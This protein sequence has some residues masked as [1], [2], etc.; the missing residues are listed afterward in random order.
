MKRI[1]TSFCTTL[2]M[3]IGFEANAGSVVFVHVDGAGISHWQIGRA[4]WVGP[5]GDLHWDKLENVAVYR[6]LMSDSLTASSNGGATAHAYGRR[7]HYMAFGGDTEGKRALNAQGER[8]S[9]T[10]EAIKAGL[11]T[12]LVNSGSIIEPGTSAFVATVASRAEDSAEV[13]LQVV[14]SGVDVILSG[15]EEWLLPEGETGRYGKGARKDGRNLIEE[16]RRRGYRVVFTREELAAVPA[17]TQKLLGVFCAEDTFNDMGE[18]QMLAAGLAPYKPEAPTLAEMTAKALEILGHGGKQFFLAVEEEGTD[19]FGNFT[20]AAGVIEAV[21]RADDALGVALKF[22][23]E[24]DDTLLITTADSEAG[25]MEMLGYPALEKFLLLARQGRDPTGAEWDRNVMGGPP[26]T[27]K[28]DRRLEEAEPFKAKADAAGV[29][30]PFVVTWA[31]TYDVS[32]GILVRA[33]GKNSGRV[34]GSMLNTDVYRIM[35]ETL[36]DLPD[37]RGATEK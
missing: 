11:R 5:D 14:E 19:N 7:P 37:A 18:P 32:G 23:K 26:F 29:E 12:G 24:R 25:G 1:L 27:D 13:A 9:L 33:A 15:G 36:F 28:P 4:I 16:A 2:A 8:E 10:H 17:D 35:R 3:A 21:K 34:R 22:C 31:T 6:G 20:N 30:L